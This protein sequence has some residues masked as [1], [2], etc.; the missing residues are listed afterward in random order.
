MKESRHLLKFNVKAG[1]KETGEAVRYLLW[2]LLIVGCTDAEWS[3]VMQYGSSQIVKCY[4][5]GQLI[6]DGKSTGKVINEDQSD[7]YSFEEK[8]TGKLVEISADC[9][10]T[11]AD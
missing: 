2:A 4:S 11:S 3:K 10:F 9:I 7:G 1:E 6:Y 5:G 8:G